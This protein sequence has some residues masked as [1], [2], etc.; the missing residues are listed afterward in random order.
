MT[1]KRVV[2]I[3]Q[4]EIAAEFD[5]RKAVRTST[6]LKHTDVSEAPAVAPASVCRPTQPDPMEAELQELNRG[7]VWF[8]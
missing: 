7:I 2:V 3:P 8:R 1:S 6:S 5:V 4:S